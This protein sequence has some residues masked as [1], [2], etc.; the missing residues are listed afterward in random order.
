[1]WRAALAMARERPWL[2]HGPDSYRRVYGPYM[3]RV[4][5]DQTIH[6]NNVVFELL[7]TTGVLGLVA[8]LAVVLLVAWRALQALRG[9]PAGTETPW[10]A[11]A[12]AMLAA[13][14]AHGLVDYFLAFTAG[15]VSV[16]TLAGVGSGLAISTIRDNVS[17]NV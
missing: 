3:G 11:A 4:W 10:A 15:Y 1:M 8:F 5:W 17:R 9:A 7:A 12:L 6:A 2:G 16:F 14:L 13:W